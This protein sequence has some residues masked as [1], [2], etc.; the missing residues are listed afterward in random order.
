MKRNNLKTV[1]LAVVVMMFLAQAVC[2][3]PQGDYEGSKKWGQ[4]GKGHKEKLFAELNFTDEQKEQLKANR[5]NNRGKMKELKIVLREKQKALHDQIGSAT[6]SAESIKAAAA[7]VKAAQNQLVDSRTE[8]ILVVKS[9]LTPEQYKQFSEKMKEKK[10]KRGKKGKRRS[11][12]GED[13]D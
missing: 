9:I 3:Q 6:A 10:D 5:E 4:K 8:G 2:A 1:G 13:E 11:R 12:R 7:A